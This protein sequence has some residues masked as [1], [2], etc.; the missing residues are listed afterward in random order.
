MSEQFGATTWAARR[1]GRLTVGERLRETV[2]GARVLIASRG[3]RLGRAL[4]LPPR[5]LTAALAEVPVPRTPVAAAAERALAATPPWVIGHSMRT[6]L[7][8]ALLGRRDGLAVDHELLFAAA[9]LHDLG[10][11]T[12]DGPAC[13]AHRGAELARAIVTAAGAPAAAAA[14]IADAICM[15]LDVVPAGLP[16]AR[17][18][19]AGAGLDVVGERFDDLARTTRRAVVATWPRDGFATAVDAALAGE[20][21][22]HP[23]TRIGLLCHRLGFR[24]LIAEADRRFAGDRDA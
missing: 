7:W 14:R 15:H 3:G 10:L 21:A 8:G 17:L 20:A 2:H 9:A 12:A 19:R 16:E 4:G 6:Y 22:R 13:F 5:A 1:D 23:G 18:V 11:V 24:R